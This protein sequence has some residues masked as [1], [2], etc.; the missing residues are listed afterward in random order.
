MKFSDGETMI[1]K[2]EYPTLEVHHLHYKNVGLERQEDIIVL[3]PECHK[4]E[5]GIGI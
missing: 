3:C 1:A 2:R 4:K 5:H